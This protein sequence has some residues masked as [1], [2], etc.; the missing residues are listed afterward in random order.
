LPFVLLYLEACVYLAPLSR[1]SHL[2]FFQKGS[3]RREDRSVVGQSVLN[4]TLI[5]YPLVAMLATERAR[6]KKW[7]STKASD[8]NTGIG[9]PPTQGNGSLFRKSAIP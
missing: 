4:I 7:R 5:S 9:I 3:S 1:Y 8:G 2:K 6:S